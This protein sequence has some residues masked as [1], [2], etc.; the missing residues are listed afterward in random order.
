M[1]YVH[2]AVVG[3]GLAPE[4]QCSQVVLVT[5]AYA[6]VLG[7]RYL[8]AWTQEQMIHRVKTVC[9]VLYLFEFII[10]YQ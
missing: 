9:Y 6:F 10:S 8:L 1:L 2:D 5:V 4:V 7:N 3:V